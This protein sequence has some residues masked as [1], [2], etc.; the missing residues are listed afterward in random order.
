MKTI[1][2]ILGIHNHQPIGNFDSV[3][4]HAF[5]HSYQPFLNLLERY[6]QIRLSQHYSGILLEW[7]G[8]HRPEMLKQ[9][10][11][12]VRNRQIEMMGGAY[13]EAILS[14]IPD[15]DKMCQ[16][17]KLSGTIRKLFGE[18]PRGMWLAERVWEQ[19]LARFIADAGLQ[20]IVVDDTHFKCAGFSDE[21]LLGYYITEEQGKTVA[22]FPISK[23]LRY[24]V[25]FQPV[26]NTIEY[27]RSLATEEGDRIVVFADDGEKFGVWPKTFEHVYKNGWLEDFFKALSE[28]S[29]W[30]KIQHF[31]EAIAR[32]PA[33]GRTYLPNAS[34]AEM[35]HWAL[36]SHHFSLYE[37]FE[38]IL[39]N[40]GLLERFESFFKGGFWRNFLVK[41]PETNT[42]HKKMMRVSQR[43]HR[44]SQMRKN[45]PVRTM[46]RVWTAQ[47]NDAYWHGVFG[48]LYLPVLRYPIYHN[49]IAAETDLDKIEG[50]TGIAV[51]VTDFDCDGQT[52][53]LVE[54]PRLNCYFKPDSGGMMFELDF[55]PI[56]LNLLDIVSRREEGYHHKLTQAQHGG[57]GDVASI[58]DLV[59]AKE[60]GLE[61]HLHYD[62]HRRGSLID[63][64]FGPRTT[65][66][67]VWRN[68][69]EEEGDFV[70]KPYR[71]T[72]KKSGRQQKLSFARNGAVW[73]DD[74]P[75]HLELR[76]TISLSPNGNDLEI[77]YVLKNQEAVPFD[78]WFGIEFNVGLQAGNAPDR[79]YYVPG[80]KLSEPE[81]R[82][83]GEVRETRLLGVRDEW[84]G[85]DVAIDVGTSTTFWRFPL[86]TIS[87]SESGFERIYQSSVLLPHW[88]VRLEKTWKCSLV[89]RIRTAK[90]KG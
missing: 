46:E 63:H 60:Q 51:E 49:L 48:G 57:G 6:P 29:D 7:I 35:M 40:Q 69:Y 85:I 66:E 10:R 37:E 20:Y 13:Y 2:L 11:R 18:A 28:N 27:L 23:T 15:D 55:K 26:Q 43:A 58:H 81:L 9:V 54:T 36:P 14:I 62:W 64:F 79:Y 17:Q 77:E 61:N 65:L 24:T 76:K 80:G 19:H 50:R 84:L 32:F 89:Q 90:E 25:P 52:E 22:I 8:S 12:M 71:F 39:K 82:S 42:M 41:Y 33:A 53:V 44:L 31:S 68:K 56:S 70:N 72:S 78:I 59:V 30:I 67:D 74:R 38:N 75:H 47:C 34:Y 73:R 45:V 4:E 16:L 1:N 3:L 88:K 21:E 83:K 5:E 87:L 86:E